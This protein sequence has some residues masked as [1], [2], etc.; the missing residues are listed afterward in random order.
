MK[1]A[2]RKRNVNKNARQIVTV[3]TEK[4]YEYD[5]IAHICKVA[6]GTVKRWVST[7]RADAAK[8]KALENEIGP[9]YLGSETV[10]DIL[11]EIYKTRKRRYRIKRIQLK[12]IAGRST[13][14]HSFVDGIIQHLLNNG[15]FML[16]AVAGEDDIYIIISISQILKHVKDNLKS[17]DIN[18]YYK[19]LANTIEDD[20]E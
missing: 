18:K 7:G 17:S 14:R 4:G 16:E 20:E 9:V 6:V 11:I 1:S 19:E 15:Y 3:A 8:I 13:L 10:G 12:K 5:E 2:I